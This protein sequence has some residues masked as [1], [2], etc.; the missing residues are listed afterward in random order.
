MSDYLLYTKQAMSRNMFKTFKV[1][2]AQA[3]STQKSNYS[4]TFLEACT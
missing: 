1:F 3:Y 2:V 4:G